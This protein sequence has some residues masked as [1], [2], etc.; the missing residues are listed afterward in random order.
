MKKIILILLATVFLFT[1]CASVKYT[2]VDSGSYLQQ[3]VQVTLDS[4]TLSSKGLAV[5]DVKSEITSVVNRLYENSRNYF[6][7]NLQMLIVN[8]SLT[9]TQVNEIM[10]AIRVTKKW[11]DDT[12]FIYEIIFTGVNASDLQLSYTEVF[13]LYNY[14]ST[15]P[16][17]DDDKNPNILTFNFL[18][19]K[20]QNTQTTA[21]ANN[22]TIL[23]YFTNKFG[24]YGFTEDD[25]RYVYSYG[26]NYR[27][28]H[29]D[30]DEIKYVNGIYMH[31]WEL[32]DKNEEITLYRLIANPTNWY[33]IA[34][35]VGVG[36]ALTLT[37]VSLIKQRKIKSQSTQVTNKDIHI[38]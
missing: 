9:P 13:Y 19:T 11:V 22:N 15:V 30:A 8:E 1:G 37:I 20:V 16:P 28:L 18:T 25:V 32:A 10:E 23:E 12:T 14:G 2:V 38:Q 21:F 34:L 31:T 7:N 5:E 29:S 27:R 4:N 35:C 6:L 3:N 26:T 24:E 36:T 17:E 33:I